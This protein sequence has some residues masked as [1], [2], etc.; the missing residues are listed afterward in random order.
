[1]IVTIVAGA[2]PNFMKIAPII[3]AIKIKKEQGFDIHIRLVHTGEQL[4]NEALFRDYLSFTEI[5]NEYFN[6]EI[7]DKKELYFE[8]D[9]FKLP[10][11]SFT[12][13]FNQLGF[14]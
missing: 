5:A 6:E 7:A 1:M 4:K 11:L 9:N 8:P 3:D 13:S 10:E 14:E 2:R 12:F